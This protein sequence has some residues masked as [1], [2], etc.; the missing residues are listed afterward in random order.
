MHIDIADDDYA[1]EIASSC[2]AENKMLKHLL[3]PRTD[4]SPPQDYEMLR[5][6][7]VAALR[8]YESPIL[9][10]GLSLGIDHTN[11]L[12]ILPAVIKGRILE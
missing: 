3:T 1:S 4:A 7:S 11:A 5:T 6:S 12:R 8:E 10:K 9:D 2:V